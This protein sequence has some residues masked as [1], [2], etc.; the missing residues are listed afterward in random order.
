ML[1]PEPPPP[2]PPR[3]PPPLAH[4]LAWTCR[5]HLAQAISGLVPSSPTQELAG[6]GSVFSPL[7]VKHISG[8][9]G[10]VLWP[11]LEGGGA[12]GPSRTEAKGLSFSTC[13]DCGH[14]ATLRRAEA[15]SPLRRRTPLPGLDRRCRGHVHPWCPAGPH[16]RVV[17]VP[18]P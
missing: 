5:Q 17:A 9:S 16:P 6:S 4:A 14:R 2:S 15:H 8:M 3:A 18:W 12:E 10:R 13:R 11:H 7:E 1:G